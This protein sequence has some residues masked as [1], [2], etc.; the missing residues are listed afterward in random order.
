M[1]LEWKKV[2]WLRTFLKVGQ[3]T[4]GKQKALNETIEDA[5]SDLLELNMKRWSQKANTCYREK[6][7]SILL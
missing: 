3:I 7:S 2:G 1:W 5:E 4:E 6:V